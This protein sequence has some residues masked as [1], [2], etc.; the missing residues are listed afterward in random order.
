VE[1]RELTIA[2]SPYLFTSRELAAIASIQIAD[3]VVTILPGASS[4]AGSERAAE[5]LPRYRKLVASWAWAEPLLAAGAVAPAWD[6]DDP[7]AGVRAVCEE[8]A[9]EPAWLALRPLM[10]PALFEREEDTLEVIAADLLKGGP[11]PGLL[12]P[13]SAAIDRFAADHG[14]ASARSGRA[15]VAQRAEQRMGTKLFAVALPLL[16]QAEPER[17]VEAREVLGPG[18]AALRNELAGAAE[19]VAFDGPGA[20][21]AGLRGRVEAA[22]RAHESRF[23]ASEAALA[24]CDDGLDL[25]VRISTV[26]VTAHALPVD[27]VLWSSAEAA[28]A[29][30]GGHAVGRGGPATSSSAAGSMVHV[31]G[32]GNRWVMSLTL[33]AI[34]AR[35]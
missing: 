35:G 2:L 10:R 32:G 9:E 12:I 7:M 24:R 28:G 1:A 30:P 17:L 19:A 13:I 26:S 23:A 5:V 34:G 16:A 8:V 31:A 14:I 4:R 29:M 15:S 18:L 11:D 20:V 21:D 27:A 22:A 33:R 3:R 25:A 6:G